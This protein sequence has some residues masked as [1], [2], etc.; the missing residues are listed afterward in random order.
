MNTAIQFR[1]APGGWFHYIAAIALLWS[2]AQGWIMTQFTKR[3]LQGS[4]SADEGKFAR[5]QG[6]R[7][8]KEQ[9]LNVLLWINVESLYKGQGHTLSREVF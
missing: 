7:E 2:E 6:E 5:G 4:V 8:L 1:Q 3:G 9:D